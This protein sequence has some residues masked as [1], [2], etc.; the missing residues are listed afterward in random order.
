MFQPFVPATYAG[1]KVERY[2]I[3]QRLGVPDRVINVRKHQGLSERKK[4]AGVGWRAVAEDA[5]QGEQPLI[6]FETREHPGSG[7][8]GRCGLEAREVARESVRAQPIAA[9]CVVQVDR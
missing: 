3:V 5:S 9:G 8:S 6:A 2:W 1:G 4:A 7:V